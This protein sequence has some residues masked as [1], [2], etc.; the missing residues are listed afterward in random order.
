MSET[1]SKPAGGPKPPPLTTGSSHFRIPSEKDRI[2]KLFENLPRAPVLK[3]PESKLK[4]PAKKEPPPEPIQPLG[5]EAA[6][7]KCEAA[8]TPREVVQALLGY[9]AGAAKRV[10][11]FFPRGHRLKGLDGAG[12][13]ISRSSI[14]TL[15][16]DLDKPSVF[17][18][19]TYGAACYLGPMPRT[20]TNDAF[21]RIAGAQRPAGALI[22][23]VLAGDR[24]AN[25][26]YLDNGHAR[27]IETDL[28]D[29]L[30]LTTAAGKAYERIIRQRRG[31]EDR[32]G[33]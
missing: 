3:R 31:T 15:D 9:G 4:T 29:L 5:R 16:L 33:T 23:P 18:N 1:G 7:K 25:L 22:V 28:G 14:A 32:K 24:A 2:V 13:G 11:I 21:V 27:E 17:R 10:V 26:L 20:E 12:D 6:M 19:F 8:K 30:L